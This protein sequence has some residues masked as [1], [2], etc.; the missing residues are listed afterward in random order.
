MKREIEINKTTRE[1]GEGAGDLLME[2][3]GFFGQALQ[4]SEMLAL[5]VGP[6]KN[7]NYYHLSAI[8][9]HTHA[10]P[11]TYPIHGMETQQCWGGGGWG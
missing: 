10:K 1:G 7:T 8:K 4:H 5:H 3:C 11:I 9:P 2:L 6:Q